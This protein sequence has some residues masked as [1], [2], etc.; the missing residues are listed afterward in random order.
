MMNHRYQSDDIHLISGALAKAQGM[1]KPLVPS[2]QGPGGLYANLGDI[3][4]ATRE[5]LSK[6]NISI[7]YK[8]EIA[9]EGAGAEFLWTSICHESGQYMRSCARFI[10]K[11][12]IRETGNYL[13]MLKRMET[14]NILGIAPSKND[15]IFF[16][17]NGELNAETYVL[18]ELKKPLEKQNLSTGEI[19]SNH[20]YNDLMIELEGYPALAKDIMQR[21]SIGTLADLPKNEYHPAIQKIRRI[22]KT[23]EEYTRRNN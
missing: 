17:D 20:Q 12:T 9:D 16:D 4:N 8:K 19:I 6:N 7:N 3:H 2:E 1:Y 5:G 15:P 11:T 22:K 13:E 21:Y 14:M 10:E 18:N 23:N